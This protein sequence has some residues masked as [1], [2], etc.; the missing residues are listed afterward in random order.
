MDCHLFDRQLDALLDGAC[1]PVEWR[2]AQA[3]LAD[4][5]RCRRLFEAL[6]GQIDML[7]EAGHAALTAS[8]VARTCGSTCAAC[9]ARLCDFVDGGLAAFDRAL[10][11]PHLTRCPACSA[12]A[13]ALARSTFV[14]P[15]FAEIAPPGSFADDVLAATSRREAEPSLGERLA[16]WLARAAARPRFSLEVAYVVTLL[17]ILLLGDP[18]RAVRSTTERGASYVQPRAE[19]VVQQLAGRLAGVRRV[20]AE[21]AGAVASVVGRPDTLAARWDAGV[22]A[23]RRWLHANLGAPIGAIVERVFQSIRAAFDALDGLV[24][25]IQPGAPQPSPPASNAVR[26]T[27]PSGPAMRLS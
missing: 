14:L 2:D 1:A 17:G 8:I 9:R 4:C 21:T 13:G 19:I 27:E 15:S 12:L 18:V 10:V 22:S 20:S 6:S 3:H 7:D 26:A 25:T 11:E 24:R 23:V 16:A 5:A